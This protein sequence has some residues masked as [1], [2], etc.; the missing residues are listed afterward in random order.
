MAGETTDPFKN[1]GTPGHAPFQVARVEGLHKAHR[2]RRG[3]PRHKMAWT[4]GRILPCRTGPIP[5]V[6][7]RYDLSATNW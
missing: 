5:P 4:L 2:L 1:L 6:H 3:S 7:G